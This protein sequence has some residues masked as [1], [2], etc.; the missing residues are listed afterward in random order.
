MAAARAAVPR[1]VRRRWALCRATPPRR[2]LSTAAPAQP[3]DE[4][5]IYD[6]VVVGGGNAGYSA[7]TTAAQSG[8]SRVLVL[9]KCPEEWAGGNSYFTAGAYR[10]AFDG[11]DDI[12]KAEPDTHYKGQEI[13]PS[14]IEM[15]PY[16][17]AD[18]QADI[19]RVTAGRADPALSGVLVA[20]SRDAIQ[21]LSE[22][23]IPFNLSFH[24]QAY[25]NPQTG[26]YQF[27][28][29]MVLSVLDGGKGLVAAHRRAAEAHKVQ[30]CYEAAVTRLL[31][32]PG[33]ADRVC[34]VEVVRD[35]RKVELSAR[36]VVL[37]SGGFQADPAKRSQY[38]GPGWDLAHV[39]GTPY[40]TGD[41]ISMA[42]RDVNAATK[43]NF[44][45][46]HSTC[47]D[48]DSPTDQGDRVVTNQYTKSGYPLGLMLNTAGERFVDEGSDFRNFTYAKFGRSILGQPGGA[49]YQLYDSRVI[50]WLREEE[51]ADDVALG[52]VSAETIEELAEALA[53]K[54]GLSNP[55]Q[56]VSTVRDYNAA[57]YEHMAE[58]YGE[59][60]AGQEA[61]E[62]AWDPAIKDGLSTIV[63]VTP[64]VRGVDGSRGS[65][66]A[67]AAAASTNLALPKTNWALPL[68]KPPFL[69]VKVTCGITFTFGGLAV[70]PETA[71][72]LSATTGKTV[73]GLYATGE[74]VGGVFYGNYP[75]GSGLTLGTVFGRIAGKEA[76]AYAEEKEKLNAALVK[77]ATAG[78]AEAPGATLPARR[79]GPE[80]R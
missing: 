8:A 2:V 38:L 70:C 39:R 52:K 3:L 28:G 41:G 24:R 45:G 6:V 9:D 56:F 16:S 43:G 67:V 48:S 11:L 61:A 25:E 32:A 60:A 30:T 79:R 31:V 13:D 63:T 50:S 54:K 22:I 47:W 69:A 73:P 49:A 17:E 74:T 40:N 44:S 65:S 20:G 23:G 29:G 66:G 36:S 21:W 5:L 46:C 27:W 18:F 37:A 51:Y 77:A 10:T 42:T 68:D 12:L 33:T 78:D 4:T 64:G 53:S 19:D 35:G 7:A 71:G 55:V 15:E 1:A 14:L 26:R 80:R 57:V 75:G 58:G 59:G 72:V 34:G 62:A 76:A